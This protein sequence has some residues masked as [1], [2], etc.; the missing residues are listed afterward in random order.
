MEGVAYGVMGRRR[1]TGLEGP[2]CCKSSRG[3][4]LGSKETSLVDYFH[5]SSRADGLSHLRE[6]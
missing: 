6:A 2:S 3:L 4:A 1:W 5:L